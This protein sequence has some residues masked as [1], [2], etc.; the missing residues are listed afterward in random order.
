M[1]HDATTIVASPPLQ[2]EANEEMRPVTT[3]E[4]G[5]VAAAEGPYPVIDGDGGGGAGDPA[6][7]AKRGI[8]SRDP[9]AGGS[10]FKCETDVV[11][12]WP[13][14]HVPNIASLGNESIFNCIC[15]CVPGLPHS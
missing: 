4:D 1:S 12:V 15:E 2:F 7:I 9:D 3:V 6:N 5:A 13:M 14:A 11:T 10:A 8:P